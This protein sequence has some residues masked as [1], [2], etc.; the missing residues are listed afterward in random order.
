[1]S[2][3]FK[4]DVRSVYF[5]SLTD[6]KYAAYSSIYNIGLQELNSVDIDKNFINKQNRFQTAMKI[7]EKGIQEEQMAEKSYVENLLDNPILKK[8][9]F[10]ILRN[11]FQ[12]IFN[13]KNENFDYI[14]FINLINNILL[15]EKNY[16][17]TV[18]LEK[19]RLEELH[20]A[21]ETLRDAELKKQ[22]EI[23]QNKKRRKSKHLTK[24]QIAQK[25]EKDLRDTYLQQH[26]Y[27]N[28]QF[29]SYFHEITP[30]IDNI[31][32]KYVNSATFKILTSDTF[33][34]EFISAWQS[35]NNGN[36]LQMTVLNSVLNNISEE[37][38]AIVQQITNNTK[39]DKT[40]SNIVDEL[41]NNSIQNIDNSFISGEESLRT[42]GFKGVKLKRD[43]KKFS[44]FI[45]DR[46]EELADQLLSVYQFL[47]KG[48]TLGK[49]INSTVATTKN[50]GDKIADLLTD[51]KTKTEQLRIAETNETEAVFEINKNTQSYSLTEAKKIVSDLKRRISRAVH[52]HIK[53]ALKEEAL[54]KTNEQIVSEIQSSYNKASVKISGASFSEVIDNFIQRNFSNTQNFFAGPKNTK[55]D[56]ITIVVKNP[57]IKINPFENISDFQNTQQTLISDIMQ[58]VP[59]FYDNFMDEINPYASMNQDFSLKK[60][61]QAWYKAVEKN[62]KRLFEQA[63]QNHKTDAQM[64]EDLKLLAETIKNSVVVT[65]TMKTFNQYNNDIGF[66]NGS[67]G[68]TIG[69]QLENIAELFSSAGVGLSQQE[70]EYLEFALINCSDETIG[71]KKRPAL[72]KFLSLLTSFAIFDEG[73]AELESIVQK[74]A[75]EYTKTEPQHMHLYRLNGIYYPGSYILQRIYDNLQKENV[76]KALDNNDGAHIYANASEKLIDHKLIGTTRWADVYTKAQK[77]SV[78]SINVS[79]LSNIVNL[80]DQLFDDLNL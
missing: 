59:S 75:N 47:D 40:C 34:N 72:E 48:S 67:L 51:L 76:D 65:T 14:K 56:T 78:T 20:Q 73:S 58:Q 53:I 69:A 26:T 62:N 4:P 41:I 17:A 66:L 33:L 27:S 68:G 5:N 6:K 31:L 8:D 61:K 52:R 9:D 28:S 60:G 7:L 24:D 74:L 38:P 22:Y 57:K 30:T 44:T 16:R 54:V 50:K 63:K 46:G 2:I 10:K 79:F 21:M 32:A 77:S 71:S 45:Q 23:E 12:T 29:Q 19:K 49:I 1:M 37:I 80:M 70:I 35:S 11:N 42:N 36:T 15:G 43:K 39:F 55:S 25:I 13:P 3:D 64:A 18:E